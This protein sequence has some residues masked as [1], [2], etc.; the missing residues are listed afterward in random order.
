M[1]LT[2]SRGLNP[3]EDLDDFFTIEM[4]GVLGQELILGLRSKT[5]FKFGATK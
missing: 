2:A 1:D 4:N 5:E 3:A